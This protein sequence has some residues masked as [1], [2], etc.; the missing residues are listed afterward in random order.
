MQ[1]S[2]PGAGCDATAEPM[3]VVRPIAVPAPFLL[4]GIGYN[5]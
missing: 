3:D 2:A 4:P 5:Q 1:Q